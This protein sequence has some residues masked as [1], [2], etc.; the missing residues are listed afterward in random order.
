MRIFFALLPPP[1]LHC[2]LAGVTHGVNGARW[3]SAEQL[4]LTLRFVGETSPRLAEELALALPAAAI[5]LPALAIDGVGSFQSGTH[6]NSLWVRITPAEALLRLHHKID[7]ICQ[8]H[9][10]E[11]EGR[12]YLPHLTV[13][14][15][16]RSAGP[17]TNWLAA[18]AGFALDGLRFNRCCLMESVRSDGVQHYHVLASTRLD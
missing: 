1:D 18:H 4:H 14:R 16:P 15:L 3:Q 2:R 8:Q 5:S 12:A 9:G 7:R 13:A 11:P 17:V 10:L 6:P